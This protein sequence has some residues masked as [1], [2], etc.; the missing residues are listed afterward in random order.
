MVTG[1][2]KERIAAAWEQAGP[3][4]P[5]RCAEGILGGVE[6]NREIIFVPRG[7]AIAWWVERLFPS[8]LGKAI[9]KRMQRTLL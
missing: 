3:I 1:L 6:R 2:P 8:Y 5:E 9:F 7:T 4:S